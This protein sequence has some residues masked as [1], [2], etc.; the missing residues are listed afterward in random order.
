MNT[1][2]KKWLNEFTGFCWGEA[3]IGVTRYFRRKKWGENYWLFR[4]QIKISLRSDDLFLLEDFQSKLGG[5]IY[6]TRK[7]FVY[8]IAN[9]EKSYLQKPGY[10]WI[11]TNHEELRKIVKILSRSLLS[12][13][14]R[15]SLE[16]MKKFLKLVH[17]TG[18]KYTKVEWEEMERLR[19]ESINATKFNE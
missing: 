13:K 14:K 4:G 6:K 12:A 1:I 15:E 5:H 9:K 3:Y 19:Q 17:K 2:S 16:V 7:R 10:G 18:K 8:N 11:V